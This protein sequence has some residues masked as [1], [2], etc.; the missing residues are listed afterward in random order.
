[1]SSTFFYFFIQVTHF[2]M[3]KSI[4]LGKNRSFIIKVAKYKYHFFYEGIRNDEVAGRILYI[5]FIVY[6]SIHWQYY[7]IYEV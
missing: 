6:Y 5:Q 1:M 7:S 4:I 2:E 3:L